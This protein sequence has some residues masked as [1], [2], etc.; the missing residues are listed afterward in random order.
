MSW[1]GDATS[2][3]FD[4][5]PQM[6][7]ADAVPPDF[8]VAPGGRHAHDEEV[9]SPTGAPSGSLIGPPID[10][11][12]G[13]RAAVACPSCGVPIPMALMLSWPDGALTGICPRC[14]NAVVLE[15]FTSHRDVA[16]W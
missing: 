12:V 6:G 4:R 1:Y 15:T 10:N 16:G 9:R 11:P 7:R 13:A 8:G 3:L 5:A 2:R 14:R